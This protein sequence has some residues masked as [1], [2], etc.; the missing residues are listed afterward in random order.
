MWTD[1]T[2]RNSKLR[3]LRPTFFSLQLSSPS[4]DR[5]D[6]A[7]VVVVVVVL[8]L[9]L[10]ADTLV[11]E[12]F[13][14]KVSV[15]CGAAS[16][17]HVPCVN[18]TESGAEYDTFS[19][20]TAFTNEHKRTT[21]DR[22]AISAVQTQRSCVLNTASQTEGESHS[23]IERRCSFRITFFL[24]AHLVMAF[25]SFANAYQNVWQGRR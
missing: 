18:G 25:C 10:R 17:E 4:S 7:V 5:R 23:L 15:R 2:A 14:A 16:R 24:L 11:S 9:L 1:R 12:E 20:T 22:A 13:R 6:S 8:L 21:A 3:H 19:I